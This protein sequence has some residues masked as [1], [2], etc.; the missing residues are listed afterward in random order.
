MLQRK[1]EQVA[2]Y[3]RLLLPVNDR[4]VLAAISI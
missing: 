1:L 4:Q 3:Q 2:G